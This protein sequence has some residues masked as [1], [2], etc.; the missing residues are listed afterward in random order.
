MDVRVCGKR[1]GVVAVPKC[2]S[3][4]LHIEPMY[5]LLSSSNASFLDVAMT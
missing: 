4:Q 5:G 2:H 1:V 3:R